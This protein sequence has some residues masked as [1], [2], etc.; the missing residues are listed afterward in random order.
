[1]TTLHPSQT[2]PR[3]TAPGTA[4]PRSGSWIGWL[5]VGAFVL[6]TAIALLVSGAVVRVIDDSWR[7]DGYLTS[8]QI[9]LTTTSHAISTERIDLEDIAPLW[10]DIDSLL[11][12]VRLRAAGTAGRE[13]FVGVAP[14]DRAAAYLDGVGHTTLSELADPATSYREH[15]GGAP[16]SRPADQD[17]WV[18]EATGA[19]AQ[20]VDWPMEDG[21][22]TVVVMNADGSPGVQ[23]T[24]DIGA[25]VPVQNWAAQALLIIGG[26]LLF[27]G[28]VLVLVGLS[29]RRRHAR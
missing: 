24:V 1:M 14:A 10:P 12:D 15:P 20:A 21:T 28:L 16:A 23:A 6:F 18:A 27:P 29:Q 5:I 19:G 2:P 4:H 17:F 25:T 26:A 11:G 9:P 7:R 8:S 3:S 22:W 13:I